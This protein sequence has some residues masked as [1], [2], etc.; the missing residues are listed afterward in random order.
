MVRAI[1]P[2]AGMPP[3]IGVTT[4]ATPCAISSVFELCLSPI[5]PSATVAESSDSMAPSMAMVNAVGKSVSMTSKFITGAAAFGSDGSMVNRS[6]MVSMPVMPNFSRRKY[7]I[8]VIT[9]IAMSEPGI[10][11]E[12]FGLSAIIPIETIPTAAAHQLM[13]VKV[14]K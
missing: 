6:P 3:K 12:I 13:L 9:T 11:F 7:T 10:F 14:W 2:V 5:T 8:T 4:L 1:A